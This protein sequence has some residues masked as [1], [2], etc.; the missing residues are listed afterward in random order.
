M[1]R[2]ELE[3][4]KKELGLQTKLACGNEEVAR[5]QKING[6]MSTQLGEAQ[7]HC[8]DL[9]AAAQ[10]KHFVVSASFV[11]VSE[12]LLDAY[13]ACVLQ[14]RARRSTM[15][16]LMPGSRRSQNGEEYADHAWGHCWDYF[17]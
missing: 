3:A 5:L 10:G 9:V 15:T 8:Q 14:H 4:L 11:S 2:N 13:V 7:Q 16:M 12:C 17:L 6:D 1:L